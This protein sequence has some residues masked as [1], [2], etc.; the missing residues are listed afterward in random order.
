MWLRFAR[1]SD[2]QDVT[3]FPVLRVLHFPFDLV[4]GRIVAR[5]GKDLLE[6]KRNQMQRNVD[7]AVDLE[8][9]TLMAARMAGMRA[10]V[11]ALVGEGSGDR[12]RDT[13]GQRSYTVEG[14]PGREGSGP[15]VSTDSDEG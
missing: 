5:L 12:V 7:E 9:R 10:D 3:A 11:E 8:R 13:C 15:D 4:L 2:H 6:L 1:A 14:R